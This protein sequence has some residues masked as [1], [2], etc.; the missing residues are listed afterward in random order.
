MNCGV[1]VK[2]KQNK[3]GGENSMQ[4]DGNKSLAEEEMQDNPEEEKKKENKEAI[5]SI[6]FTSVFPNNEKQKFDTKMLWHLKAKKAGDVI[7][8]AFFQHIGML[9][10]ELQIKI[11]QQLYIGCLVSVR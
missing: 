11:H 2:M 10:F 7:G 3:D 9:L 5:C 8:T 6:K 4:H 1:T